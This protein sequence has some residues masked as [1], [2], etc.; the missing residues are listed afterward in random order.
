MVKICMGSTHG[1]GLGCLSGS[2]RTIEQLTKVYNL[3]VYTIDEVRRF[4]HKLT[5][6]LATLTTTIAVRTYM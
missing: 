3:I 4:S 5:T 6:H 2:P 1:L